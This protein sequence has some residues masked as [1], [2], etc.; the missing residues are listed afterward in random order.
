MIC[1]FFSSSLTSDKSKKNMFRFGPYQGRGQR[2][3]SFSLT[4]LRT[5]RK[6]LECNLWNKIS[7]LAGYTAVQTLQC[8]NVNFRKRDP[9]L[10]INLWTGLHPRSSNWLWQ[11]KIFKGSFLWTEAY[12]G[13]QFSSSFKSLCSHLSFFFALE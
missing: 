11:Q 6:R 1:S 4:S 3:S 7:K 10:C 13:L 5:W 8:K 9:L 12:L 2:V